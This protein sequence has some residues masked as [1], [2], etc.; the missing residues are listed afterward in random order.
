[1]SETKT[2][3][4]GLRIKED[5]QK[6]VAAEAI[7]EDRSWNWMANKLISEALEARKAKR[8]PSVHVTLIA[9]K[10]RK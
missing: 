9:D 5:L 3:P 8:A 7:A 6:A 4:A 2:V 1:M 10:K